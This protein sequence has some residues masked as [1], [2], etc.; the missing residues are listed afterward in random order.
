MKKITLFLL[1]SVLSFSANS[2]TKNSQP[3]SQAK[4]IQ[5]KA[6]LSIDTTWMPA[7]DTV[8]FI[9]ERDINQFLSAIGNDK[10][11]TPNEFL[12]IRSAFE[13]VMV[14]SINRKRG[15]KQ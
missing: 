3:K 9:S 11:I 14:N 13:A 7:T 10:L 15:K 2:Q 8:E 5:P 6:E 4:N 12:K 1:I